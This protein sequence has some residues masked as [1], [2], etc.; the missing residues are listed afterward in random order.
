LRAFCKHMMAA[1][2]TGYPELWKPFAALA[3]YWKTIFLAAVAIAGAIGA[4]AKWGWTPVAW[5]LSKLAQARKRRKELSLRFVLDEHR[6]LWLPA[7][8]RQGTHVRGVWHVTNTSNRDVVI[9]KARFRNHQAQH[10]L[11]LASKEDGSAF[12]ALI[13]A[14]HISEIMADWSPVR[15][16]LLT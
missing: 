5:A 2:W 4:F 15:F 10:S 1:A 8:T 9:L 3:E 16:W 11:V 14:Q 7:G 6:S 12:G 13:R